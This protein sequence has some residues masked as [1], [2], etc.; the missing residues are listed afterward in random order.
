MH[1]A[2]GARRVSGAVV[3]IRL[4][5]VAQW[6]FADISC[7]CH[8]EIDNKPK[9]QL[10]PQ[11]SSPLSDSLRRQPWPQWTTV[12][13]QASTH[14][15]DTNTMRSVYRNVNNK[16]CRKTWKI[17]EATSESGHIR[18]HIQLRAVNAFNDTHAHRHRAGFLYI[19]WGA[20]AE[21]R[22]SLDSA[23]D[24]FISH[25]ASVQGV[26]NV[27]KGFRCVFACMQQGSREQVEEITAYGIFHP[28]KVD[29]RR[30]MD[31]PHIESE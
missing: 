19:C 1:A 23:D 16:E 30:K 7:S 14:K 31:T 5:A 9:C 21:I 17:V 6:R 22:F 11:Q 15:T 28:L 4:R 18:K 24:I 13:R 3:V 27:F 10:R 12:S 8:L 25:H 20:F 29:H 2:G 26:P